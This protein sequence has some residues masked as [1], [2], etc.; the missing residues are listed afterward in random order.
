MTRKNL[1][2][3]AIQEQDT[4]LGILCVE[5]RLYAFLC[6]LPACR[7]I[8]DAP[9][10]RSGRTRHAL[11]DRLHEA[12][13]VAQDVGSNQEEVLQMRLEWRAAQELRWKLAMSATRVAQREARR[14]P[15]CGISVE[16]LEQEAIIAL[17]CAAK[18]FEPAHGVRFAVYARWWVRAEI[19]RSIQLAGVIRI[20]GAAAELHR[21]FRKMVARDEM[22]GRSRPL[23]LLAAELGVDPS[24]LREAV[25]AGAMRA[26]DGSA[27][28]EAP[29]SIEELP[30]HGAQSP[31]EVV[32]N[33]QRAAWLQEVV[34]RTLT[35][36]E[37]Y[38]MAR[39]H[40]LGREV[41]SLA[42]IA[43]DLQLSGERVRQLEQQCLTALRGT[44]SRERA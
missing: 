20:S 17:Y 19:T 36:R 26:A 5:H 15:S 8:L 9:P 1:S 34:E 30:D 39:R 11:V 18:R 16:D 4:A 14:A 43:G 33:R 27:D 25:A 28:P 12:L 32:S 41:C 35:E 40:G 42:T 7:A 6:A 38:I 29:D 22:E 31:E 10:T 23:T 44:C 21:N 2:L 37:R 3:T 24:R 13:L